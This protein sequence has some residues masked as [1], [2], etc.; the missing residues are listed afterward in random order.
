[1]VSRRLPP[2]LLL[3]A[4]AASGC[5]YGF[6]PET[7]V[8]ALRV[9]SVRSTPADLHPGET[10]SLEALAPDPSRPG[11]AVTLLWIGCD[12]DPYNLGR[13]ACADTNLLQ[14]P[15]ALTGGTGTLPPGVS[16]IGFNGLARWTAPPTLFD[17]LPPE[18]PRRLTGTVGPVVLFAVAEAVS[19]TATPAELEALFQRVQRR[20]VRSVVSLY[21]VRVSEDA[22]RNHA[23]SLT[24]LTVGGEPW[25]AGARVPVLPGQTLDL[26][27]AAP[28]EAF[29]AY[30]A[31]TPGGPQDRT[32]RLLAAW[33][34]T[35]GRFSQS[36][37]ALGEAVRT[38]FTGPGGADLTDPVPAGRGGTLW[39]V[40]RDTRGGQTWASWSLYVCDPAL[41]AP[42][43]TQVDWPATAAD[44]LVLH[45]TALG[46]V[47]DVVVD[48]QAL[49]RGGFSAARGTW[50][51]PLPPGVDPGAPRGTVS[52]RACGRQA[53][54]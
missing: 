46:S 17:V 14:D 34:G 11:G 35:A 10:A 43:V 39:A 42:V 37:T 38:T 25:P 31:L 47:L 4:L 53:L 49:T 33:Y 28:P 45:G 52:S 22:Q 36:R 8:D 51:G 27:L 30:T 50:E 5:D 20:E 9:L 15:G 12:A 1:V 2:R 3:L 29:E 6:K 16:L 32:E 24:G 26:D 54:P 41:P 48:G 40:V 7:L 18:D 13:T 19:P 21:R 44:L 23:P